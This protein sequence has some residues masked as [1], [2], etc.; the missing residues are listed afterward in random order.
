LL[1]ISLDP[2]GASCHLARV[3]LKD[4]GLTSHIL[5]VANSPLYNRSG[6]SIGSIAH[7]I[8]LLGWD[9][10]RNLV[11]A[12]RFVEHYAGKSPGLRE[13]MV[14]SLISAAQARHVSAAVGYAR[15]EEAYVCGLFRN[16]GEV[17]MARY[18]AHEYAAMIDLM[19]RE[20]ISE[21]AAAIRVCDVVPEEIASNLANAWNLPAAVRSCL[22]PAPPPPSDRCLKSV[23]NYSHELA[24]ALYR[25]GA[26]FEAVHL[27]T[28]V[29]PS[30]KQVLISQRDLRRIVD[31]AIE[32]THHTL[33]ALRIGVPA[34]HLVRQAEQAREL[35]EASTQGTLLRYDLSRMDA[36]IRELGAPAADIS[37]MANQALE[38]L[39]AA[40]G[41]ERAVLALASED[42]RWVHGRMASGDVSLLDRFHFPVGQGDPALDVV[43]LRGKDLW[44]KRRVDARYEKSRLLT[45][46]DPSHF[47]LFRIAMNGA[48]MGVL[49]ADRRTLQ[50]PD[51]MR[52]RL[53]E[54]R[55]VLA[56]VFGARAVFEAGRGAGVTR[57]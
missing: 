6:K 2:D 55:D 16:L 10:I 27:K 24:A 7:A 47:A 36:G 39:T 19:E 57:L 43:M 26:V 5:R 38:L 14:L 50:P 33:T 42:R 15:P 46:F 40:G 21:R 25:R 34:L 31:V 32:D 54:I 17:V 51:E 13:L 53:E 52:A 49:Y 1:A 30:G 18:Y 44:I 29:D 37:A 35:L 9:T 48:S 41:F 56:R 4:L 11:G 45:A 12:M 3:I 28:V 20:R 8:T 22:S 23:V